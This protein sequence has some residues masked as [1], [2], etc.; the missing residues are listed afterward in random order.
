MRQKKRILRSL[1]YTALVLSILL[2]IA[3]WPS[4]RNYDNVF[5][6]FGTSLFDKNT[7]KIK[8]NED[9][10][11]GLDVIWMSEQHQGQL[12]IRKGRVEG[13][14]KDD[15]GKNIFHV[16]YDGCQVIELYH[17]KTNWWHVHDYIFEV[18]SES[19]TLKLSFIA[20]GPDQYESNGIIFKGQ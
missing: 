7:Y 20:N 10:L 9:V 6:K 2:L 4:F 3:S 1:R 8:G 17:Y 18:Y 19:D 15:Y 5:C 12:L 13:S 16:L 14:I 11:S